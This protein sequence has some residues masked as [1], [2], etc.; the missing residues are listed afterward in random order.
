[1]ETFKINL[2]IIIVN[3][4]KKMFVKLACDNTLNHKKYYVEKD[5]TN[6]LELYLKH[7]NYKIDEAFEDIIEDC[8][9]P[10]L[11][12]RINELRQFEIDVLDD[13]YDSKIICEKMD[14]IFWHIVNFI[15]LNEM[16]NLTSTCADNLV[17]DFWDIVNKI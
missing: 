8:L 5:S 4:M 17:Y 7:N 11:I 13:Y 16:H 10:E 15:G 14:E 3:Y 9:S 12:Q 1:M 2:K 6:R